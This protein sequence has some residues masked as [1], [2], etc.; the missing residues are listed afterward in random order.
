MR[1]IVGV[2]ALYGLLVFAIVAAALVALG[3]LWLV[4]RWRA[5][6]LVPR[7]GIAPQAWVR[8]ADGDPQPFAAGDETDAVPEGGYPLHQMVLFC[9]ACGRGVPES[10]AG[11][12][13]TTCPD[14]GGQ[15]W[16]NRPD[17][18]ILGEP[19]ERAR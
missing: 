3:L 5:L 10:P 15:R 9:M 17:L 4:R 19:K 8:D 18:P 12:A 14:C 16:S 11:S 7:R 6:S 13:I 2:A 1:I